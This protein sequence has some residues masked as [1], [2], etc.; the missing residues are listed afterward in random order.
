MSEK[1]IIYD[2][3]IDMLE[4]EISDE[5]I[6]NITRKVLDQSDIKIFTK[7][8]SSSG[9]YHPLEN[10][11][12]YGLLKHTIKTI[13]VSK[14]LAY[15]YNIKDIEKDA[16]ISACILHDI[17]KFDSITG[18]LLENHGKIAYNHIIKVASEFNSKK[19]DMIS[20]CVRYHMYRF[21]K[22]YV[23]KNISTDHPDIIVKIV[24]LS[25]FISSR[26][27]IPFFSQKN[28]KKY[29][30]EGNYNVSKELQNAF[31]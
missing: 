6:K 15:F 27:N 26:K 12:K 9:K 14:E 25:D 7:P 4:K 24:Q 28:I 30:S 1:K 31:W 5:D 13:I 22:S 17:S 19:V 29:F 23:E 20:K 11:G 3:I 16:V 2:F 10:N 21:T 8:S 18:K